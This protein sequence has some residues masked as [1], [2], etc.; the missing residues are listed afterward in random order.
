[1]DSKSRDLILK[2]LQERIQEA[3]NID[4]HNE[5]FALESFYE[6]FRESFVY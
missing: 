2:E 6:W 5:A 1:M 3:R 4:N